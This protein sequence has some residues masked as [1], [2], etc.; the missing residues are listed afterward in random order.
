MESLSSSLVYRLFIA[1]LIFLPFGASLFA[2]SIGFMTLYPFLIILLFLVAYSWVNEYGQYKKLFYSFPPLV[3]Y[4]IAFL[5]LWMLYSVIY[6]FFGVSKEDF[7]I[8]IRSVGLFLLTSW[9]VIYARY[10][11]AGRW[12]ATLQ[13]FFTAFYFFLVIV[14]LFEIITGIHFAGAFTKK[15]E[16]IPIGNITYSPVF[17]YDNPNNYATYLTLTGALSVLFHNFK[18]RNTLLV[19]FVVLFNYLIY[20]IISGRIGF[21]IFFFSC[22]WL[23]FYLGYKMR[24]KEHVRK[25]MMYIGVLL[26]FFIIALWILPKYYGP[27]WRKE[28][29]KELFVTKKPGLPVNESSTLIEL[30]YLPYLNKDTLDFRFTSTKIRIALIANAWEY[31]KESKG[32]GIGPGQFRYLHKIGHKKYYTKTNISPH[33]WPL[34]LLS[35]YGLLIF[36]L[37][38]TLWGW[39]VGILLQKIRSDAILSSFALLAILIFFLCSLFPSGFLILDINWFFTGVMAVVVSDIQRGQFMVA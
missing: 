25:I 19:I 13:I 24:Y 29:E 21:I 15:L 14:G 39:I 32:L 3:R 35:Q 16:E 8:D 34:E 26:V 18:E 17:I 12:Y 36:I 2:F 23:F 22:L 38:I 4:Y 28:P 11:L 5:A 27:I 9:A 7:L 10:K 20:Y 30:K 37:Y 6:G 31:I 33:N 1:L